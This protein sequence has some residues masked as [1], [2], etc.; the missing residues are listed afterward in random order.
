MSKFIRIALVG[1]LALA[2]AVASGEEERK[3]GLLSEATYNRLVKIQE[4]MTS[5]QHN[6]AIA[7]LNALV[8]KVQGDAYEYAV[9][10][11]NLGYAHIGKEDY[12]GALPHFEKAIQL[13]SLPIQQENQMVFTLAQLY[14][15]VEQYTKTIQLLE[16]WFKTAENPPTNAYI[17]MANAYSL[18]SPPRWRDAK[19]YAERAVQ[20]ME[21][22]QESYYK[23]LLAVNYELKDF[24][25]CAEV[26]EAMLNYWPDNPKYWEQLTGMYMELSDDQKALAA[27]AI[28]YRK[29]MIKD[30]KQLTNLARLFILNEAP[31]EGASVL[32]KGIEEK[33]VTPNDKTYALIAEAYVQSKEWSKATDALAKGG[34]LAPDGEMFVRKAQIHVQQLEYKAAMD[35]IDKAFAKGTLRKPGVAYMI[36]GRAA[37]ESKNFEVAQKAFRKAREFDDVKNSAASW[38]DYIQEM[39]AAR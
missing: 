37:A 21:K 17:T 34:A 18:V 36:Q 27:M 24:K 2:S 16:G 32:T 38:L 39:Q 19:P 10:S 6:E 12:K 28:A 11:Q 9:V 8:P 26:L 4:L 3:A 25:G 1:A 33:L 7:A 13:R 22:P 29:G 15:Q 35:A 23:L 20:K 31:Y 5:E 14:M 30:E